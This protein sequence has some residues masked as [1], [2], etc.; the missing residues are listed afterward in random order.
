MKEIQSD[1]QSERLINHQ[2]F[3]EEV[4]RRAEEEIENSNPRPNSI[5]A[6]LQN[7]PEAI[8]VFKQKEKSNLWRW[9]Q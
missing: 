7:N 8:K 5:E 6:I 3:I 2:K 4:H 9:K 1:K